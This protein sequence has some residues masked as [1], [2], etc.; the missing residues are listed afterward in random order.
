MAFSRVTQP[1]ALAR[2]NWVGRGDKKNAH[3]APVHAMRLVVKNV[4][5]HGTIVIIYIIK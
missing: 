5:I 4:K 1:A 3:G 2:Y